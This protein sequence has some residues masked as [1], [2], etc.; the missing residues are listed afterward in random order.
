[1][2]DSNFAKSSCNDAVCQT[3]SAYQSTIVPVY[4]PL[5]DEINNP[6]G[7]TYGTVTSTILFINKQYIYS[8]TVAF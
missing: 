4:R 5:Y 8:D 1:M 2:L 6:S 3:V 7:E